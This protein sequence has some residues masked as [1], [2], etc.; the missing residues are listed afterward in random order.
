MD[1]AQ[2]KL[3]LNLADQMR[4]A[5]QW[6]EAVRLYGQL[7]PHLPLEAVFQHNFALSLLGAKQSL[8]AVEH[9]D[10][11]LALRPDMWQSVI[12]KARALS[13][14]G[15]SLAATGLLLTETQRNP[16]RAEF[17]LEL[18]TITLH[19]Q[20]DAR[21]AREIVRPFLN[22]P[23]SAT[24]AWLT[25][26]MASLYD[27]DESPELA[28]HRARQFARASLNR[29]QGRAVAERSPAA[30]LMHRERQRVGLLSPL[31]NCSPV[32]FFCSGA[33]VNTQMAKT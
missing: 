10:K 12:V 25:D 5:Q 23:T 6:G 16:E 7:E 21:L 9:A 22:N 13:A 28:N 11:A 3:A 1:T 30:P 32:Y 31:F 2:Q 18:A 20:C 15:Q 8:K 27:R 14:L 33:G 29:G 24:D 19:D 26:I 17:A 4:L